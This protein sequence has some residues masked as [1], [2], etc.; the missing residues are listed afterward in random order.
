MKQLWSLL[1]LLV[2][3]GCGGSVDSPQAPVEKGNP[4]KMEKPAKVVSSGIVGV[5]RGKITFTGEVP[6][7]QPISMAADAVC[8]ARYQ[9]DVALTENLLVG[10]DQSVANVFVYIKSGLEGQTFKVPSQPVVLDQDGCRYHPHVLGLQAGQPLQIINSDSTLHNVHSLAE[11]QRQFNLGM[12]IPNMRTTKKFD[13]P[14][15]MVKL[16]C[17]VHP[18]MHAYIGVV[19]HPFF[20]V[21]SADGTFEIGDLPVGTYT[22]AVW[23]EELGAEEQQIEV[24]EASP[25]VANFVF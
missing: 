19:A 11:N 13:V 7:R 15:V 21:T 22:V 12:P 18:W 6:E 17:D 8:A 3:A 10:S 16:K 5:V 24:S 23:H 4:S 1:L 20:A 14:E 25:R 2:I 9:D